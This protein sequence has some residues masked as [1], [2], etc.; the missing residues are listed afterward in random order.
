M[1]KI[2]QTQANFSDAKDFYECLLQPDSTFFIQQ[3][4]GRQLLQS[5]NSP[6]WALGLLE[7]LLKSSP[8][9]PDKRSSGG[10]KRQE[11]WLFKLFR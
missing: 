9:L 2:S 5:F 10:K 4:L 11:A 6:S 1:I 8:E 7:M 3:M